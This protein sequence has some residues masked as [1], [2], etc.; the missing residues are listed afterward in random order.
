MVVCVVGMSIREP[1]Q[2]G[3]LGGWKRRHRLTPLRGVVVEE[4]PRSVQVLFMI[5]EEV[6]RFSGGNPRTTTLGVSV[7]CEPWGYPRR[8][9]VEFRPGSRAR[10]YLDDTA[11][12]ETTDVE[13]STVAPVND[14]VV[15]YFPHDLSLIHI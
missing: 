6:W 5:D 14:G 7:P 1:R 3:G 15:A 9:M 8:L 10:I 2:G 12:G 4:L 11:L 13:A